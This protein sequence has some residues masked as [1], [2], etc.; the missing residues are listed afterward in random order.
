M[1][2]W[3][4]LI[5]NNNDRDLAKERLGLNTFGIKLALLGDIKTKTTLLSGCVWD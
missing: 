2:D 3:Y 4:S 5:K 1:T